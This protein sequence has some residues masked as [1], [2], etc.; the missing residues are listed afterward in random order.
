MMARPMH[1][2]REVAGVVIAVSALA[3]LATVPFAGLPLAPVPAFIPAYESALIVSHLTTAAL[4]FGQLRYSRSRALLALASGYLF[5]ALI[6]LAHALT[7]PGLFTA[8]GLLAAGTQSTAWLFM[9]WHGGFPLFVIAYAMMKGEFASG[10]S[11]V[12]MILATIAAAALL[13]LAATAG[14]DLLPAIM[15]ANHYTSLMTTVVGI[16]WLTSFVA[17]VALWRRRERGRLDACLML[18]MFAWI[19]DI[20][21][22]AV[23]N[24][25]RFDLGFYA[26]RLY[27]LVASGAVLVVLLV[28]N[29]VLFRQLREGNRELRRAKE[30]ALSAERAKAAFVAVMSHEIRTPMNGVIGMLELISL[31]RLEGEQRTLFEVVRES[32]RSLMRIVDDVLD[33]SKI[34]AGKLDLRPEPASIEATIRRVLEVYSG[35]SSSKGLRLES[36]V[37]ERISPVVMVDE[38]RLRQILNNLVSNAIKFTAD[39]GVTVRAALDDRRPGVD[40]VRFTVE[41]TGVGLSAE[42][43]SRLFQP[44]SQAGP[45]SAGGTG[46]GLFICSRLTALMGGLLEMESEPGKGTR[47]HLTVSLPVANP[48][49]LAASRALSRINPAP[50]HNLDLAPTLEEAKRAGSLVLVVDDHPI[51][52][53]LLVKQ[54]ASLGYAA[55]SAENGLEAVR[56]WTQGGFG[57]VITDCHMP[58][59]NGYD[60][61]RHIRECEARVGAPRTP[62]IACTAMTTESAESLVAGMDDRLAKPV[63]RES[64]R[65]KLQQWL[66]AASPLDPAVIAELCQGDANDERR[67]MERFWAYNGDDARALRGCVAADDIEGVAGAAHRIVGA[68]R[69]VGANGL[70]D[71]SERIEQAARAGNWAGIRSMMPSFEHELDRIYSHVSAMK[72][73]A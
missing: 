28:Q 26:G 73:A 36:F 3:F 8:T 57:L 38:F 51:N 49:S 60:L 67:L 48:R 34:E 6:T 68:S 14:H 2:D 55:Q 44:F 5:T 4:L 19:F 12:A 41:D 58:E 47:V 7:F 9:F 16:V 37:D 45:A 21:L 18:V 72:A 50:P 40:V 63:D 70:A 42:Q 43:R 35:N 66:P 65:R 22:S 62:I 56:H 53:L 15:S 31:T 61:A 54:L 64:L 27:G 17:V 69:T 13:V 59:M 30:A 23:F 10:A 1:R 11:L 52:R 32:A 46:L 24:R 25:G 39:G 71:I 20:G 29:G 33:L